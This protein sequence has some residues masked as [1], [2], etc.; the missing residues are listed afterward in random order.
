MARFGALQVGIIALYLEKSVSS[1]SGFP[2]LPVHIGR[3]DEI[4]LPG[5]ES[6]QIPIQFHGRRCEPGEV[7]VLRPICPSFFFGLEVIKR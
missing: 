5:Y 3:N 4:I 7:D 2:E 6:E 1:K